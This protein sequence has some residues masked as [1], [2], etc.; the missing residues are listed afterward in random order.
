MPIDEEVA[1]CVHGEEIDWEI[2]LLQ[3]GVRRS[4]DNRLGTSLRK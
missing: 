1:D 4:E 3:E 2:R